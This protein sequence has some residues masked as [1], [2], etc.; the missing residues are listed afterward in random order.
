VPLP[1]GAAH[2][3]LTVMIESDPAQPSGVRGKV[4]V[5]KP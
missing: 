1:Q 4:V 2:W 5:V 3:Q